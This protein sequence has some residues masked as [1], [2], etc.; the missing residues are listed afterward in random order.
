MSVARFSAI[1]AQGCGWREKMRRGSWP[2]AAV[3]T[4]KAAVTRERRTEFQNQT[5]N[6]M[7]ELK[8]PSAETKTLLRAH[9]ASNFGLFLFVDGARDASQ[10]LST[11]TTSNSAAPSFLRCAAAAEYSGES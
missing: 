6:P 5:P 8:R 9:F 4:A 2:T 3:R 1:D 11:M 10:T 7:R